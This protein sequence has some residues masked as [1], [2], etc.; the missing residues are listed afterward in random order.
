VV[1][2]TTKT[3]EVPLRKHLVR[4]AVVVTA[5]GLVQL[6]PV[7]MAWSAPATRLETVREAVAGVGARLSF[8]ASHLAV[9]WQGE[10]EARVQLRWHDGTRWG[11]WR[12]VEH[13][14]D[15]STVDVVYGDLLGVERAQRVQARVV[16]GGARDV[17]VVAIDTRYGPRRWVRAGSAGTSS[18]ASMTDT[19]VP[20]PGVVTRAQWGADESIRK[21]TPSFAPLKKLLVHHTDTPNGDPNPAATVRAIYTY[22]V[23]TRGWNDIGYNFLV[24]ERGR[25]YE[26]RRART[27]AAG[28]VPTGEDKEG[29][30]VVGAHAEGANTGSVGV[31][32][33]GTF[34][35]QAPTSAAINGLQAMLAW[36]ADRHSINVQSGDTYPNLAGHRDTKATSCPGDRLYARLPDIRRRVSE[37]VAAAH[38]RTKGYWITTDDGQVLPFGEAR[39]FG[40]MAG[41]RLN[42]PI[43]GM[44]ATPTHGGYWLLASDG[45]IFSF[46][47]ARFH[48]STGAIRLNKPVV[49]MSSTPSGNGYWLVASDG[50]IFAFGDARFH[51]STGA[52]RLNK[53]VV[54]MAAT[55]SGRGYW[56]VASD[57]GIFA[58]GDARFFGSTGAI[59]L[60]SPIVGMST[61]A[62]GT[63]YWLVAADG[64]VFAFDVPY[65]GS[66][67][68]LRLPSY[69][70]SVALESTSTDLGYYVLSA[71]G[72]LFTFGD[73]KFLGARSTVP[74]RARDLALVQPAP[75]TP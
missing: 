50:G 49:G 1:A 22:H 71:D 48:G 40:S 41:Q 57:G 10:H 60:N 33:L 34:T 61:G 31:A 52:I 4:V 55:R 70:G 42:A 24:D 53:P 5:V 65:H 28:E 25:I 59:R 62:D 67:P 72:G 44:A 68:G 15:M 2:H 26:G 19:R 35:S 38:G 11:D 46:G 12:A 45:G 13:N 23:K 36:K 9:R 30:G 21:G 7:R 74:A 8:P 54:G 66:I 20:Q 73:A 58:F 29:R 16:G 37:M 27:Y 51:G 64:G 3:A 43:L 32:L 56:L 14:E 47:N 63:G 18:S 75:S 69:A 6:A 39:S 17:E